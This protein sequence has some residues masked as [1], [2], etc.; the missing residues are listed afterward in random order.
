[1]KA[2]RRFQPG[3]ET[4]AVAV[5][6][7]LGA[8]FLIVLLFAVISFGSV[9]TRL[10]VFNSAVREGARAAAVGKTAAESVAAVTSAAAP[11]T[12]GSTPTV[13]VGGVTYSGTQ[14]PCEDKVGQSVTVSWS[15]AFAL[16]LIFLQINTPAQQFRGVF[17]CEA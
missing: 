13:V 11:F 7:A 2:D 17:R 8:S 3:D 10:E 6:F 15:Q 12:T 9:Y 5:E 4:G 14:K 16:N 1:M